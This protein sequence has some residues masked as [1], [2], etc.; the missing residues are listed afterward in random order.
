MCSYLLEMIL[1]LFPDL[2]LIWTPVFF[3]KDLGF[4]NYFFG[5]EV[6]RDACGL[7]LS[8][9]KYALDIVYKIRLSW[10]KPASTTI[11]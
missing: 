7:Y 4:L 10:A 1:M 3:M 8:K 2:N 9:R 6:A 11:E 5:I